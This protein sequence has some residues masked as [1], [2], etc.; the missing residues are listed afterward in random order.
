MV[1]L[2]FQLLIILCIVFFSFVY[3]RLLPVN[4]ALNL[5]YLPGEF[6]VRIEDIVVITENGCV[7]VNNDSVIQTLDN[8]MWY[9]SSELSAHGY[10]KIDNTIWYHAHWNDGLTKL[11]SVNAKHFISLQDGVLGMDDKKVYAFGKIVAGASVKD[12]RKIIDS[13][14]CGY[15]ISNGKLF[16]ENKTIREASIDMIHIPDEVLNAQSCIRL[17]V[18]DNRY[19]SREVEVSYEIFEEW[20]NK[21]KGIA[22]KQQTD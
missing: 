19:Y 3:L 16:F 21:Y 13:I 17:L 2:F 7:K 5:I 1:S 22:N 9:G 20:L 6:G 4:T 10:I 8:G 12:F 15:F 18:C 14:Y 11:T